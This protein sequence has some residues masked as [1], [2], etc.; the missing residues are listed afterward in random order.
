MTTHQ[1]ND[2]VDS[3]KTLELLAYLS[4]LP[5]A[6]GEYIKALLKATG[7]S[8]DPRLLKMLKDLVVLGSI[9]PVIDGFPFRPRPDQTFKEDR[10]TPE[11]A[12]SVRQEKHREETTSE[13]GIFIGNILLNDSYGGQLIV[14]QESFGEHSAVFGTTGSGKS[15]L[16]MHIALQLREK[17]ITVIVFDCEGEYGK[18]L[19]SCDP[20]A[21]WI[22][23]PSTDR[24][25]FLEPP[26]GVPPKE[27]LNKLRNILREVFYLRDG[28]INLLIDIL[29]NLY[30]ERGVFNGS[31]DYPTI[32]DL[33]KYLDSL[34]FR[35]GSRYS[36][37]HES[38]VNRFKGLFEALPDTL[39]CK[40]GFT[41][42][43][44]KEG[45]IIIYDISSLSDDVRNFYVNF[46]ILRE[47]SYREKLPP[48]G[49]KVAFVIE[50]A[51]TLFNF[52]IAQR[53]DLGEPFVSR[54]ARTLRKR[55]IFNIYSDQVPSELPAAL[56]ANVNN[57]FVLK[58][59]NGK[60][61]RKIAQSINLT[62]EQ[63]EYLPVMEKRQC[64]V[65]SGDFPE[66]LLVEIPELS[67]EYSSPEEIEAH[68]KPI[69]E[70]L[71]Y[72][73]MENKESYKIEK[74]MDMTRTGAGRKP[75]EKPGQLWKKILEFVAEKRAVQPNEVF[76]T[77]G[78]TSIWNGRKVISAL[79]K[80][81]MIE[82]CSVCTGFRGNRKNYLTITPKGA[83]FIGQDYDQIRLLGKGSL[84]HRVLQYLIS[85]SLKESGQNVLI[86]YHFNGK[87]VD[88]AQIS[89]EK[90]IAYEIE[91]LPSH[92]HV[93]ENVIKNLEAG[94]SQVVV[95]VQNKACKEQAQK[96][97]VENVEFEK[98]TKV[99]FKLVKEF[100]P[101]TR[102]KKKK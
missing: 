83:A 97:I 13:D 22:F 43:K 71:E 57:H 53:Y 3:I 95:I 68:M 86:E 70:N 7:Y 27:F 12:E 29:T 33:I 102:T 58:T 87:S 49:M 96:Q 74:G 62:Q 51:H 4:N 81:T 79:E 54:C 65:Q 75:E 37:Y 94:F 11:T 17:G 63:A 18:L 67:F 8:R 15:I 101:K 35:P 76:Q 56:S 26:P 55:G 20:E 34:S 10:S 30:E 40:K 36:G 6:E 21:V 39:C 9:G 28:A 24:D 60:C 73:P 93:S 52:S 14:P 80:Q 5:G 72:T 82:T 85:E 47:A 2:K 91:L 98:L 16:I 92:P 41:L 44:E 46:K 89:E 31:D 38:L 19:K 48:Q 66:P 64:I 88:I 59:L 25:N 50:E 77:F 84:E 23:S 100:F 90:S 78:I 99:E 1:N 42:T 32:I 61:I 69:L 45:K